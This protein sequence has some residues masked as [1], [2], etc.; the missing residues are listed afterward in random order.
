MGFLCLD[1]RLIGG[2]KIKPLVSVLMPV[3]NGQPYLKEALTSIFDQTWD[4]LECVVIDDGST[5][6]TANYLKNI[7]HKCLRVISADH[8]GIVGA[9][10]LGLA[11]C[12]GAYIARMDA[13]DR[14]HPLR[15]EKQVAFLQNHPTIDLV[16]T[17]ANHWF[18][19]QHHAGFQEFLN[20]NNALHTH[21]QIY[22]ARFIES[23]LVHPTVMFRNHVPAQ[24]GNY[25][26]GDFPE[27]Y[28][29]WL[30][31]LD[32]GVRM[33]KLDWIGVDWRE[34]PDRLSRA[35]ARYSVKAFYQMKTDYLVRWLKQK[36]HDRVMIWGAG[37]QARRRAELLVHQGIEIAAYVDVDPV[38]IGK[39]FRGR[40]VISP[41]DLPNPGEMFILS[42][43][44]NRG[45]RAE[46]QSFLRKRGF[47]E[48][49]H[50][51]LAA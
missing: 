50:F 12:N 6:G 28:E 18:G 48:G 17:G 41:Q 45:A 30:R 46:I 23:P 31:W 13:D 22:G 8:Q 33:A 1:A 15:L 4:H 40:E 27:D 16:A 21:E 7:N 36:S 24:C 34:R 10:N 32:Q 20:W 5:D 9:L 26:M 25:R 11:A 2:E 37:Q 44:G 19:N 14:C 3:F 29:L 49:Q 51:L 47:Q 43:V 38:K 39:T 35:D 42:Y